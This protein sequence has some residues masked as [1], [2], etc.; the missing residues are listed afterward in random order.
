[1]AW[2]TI[3]PH[4]KRVELKDLATFPW[5]EEMKS[6]SYTKENIEAVK[7]LFGDE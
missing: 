4:V 1:M 7:K 5:E 2:S 3:R 6:S